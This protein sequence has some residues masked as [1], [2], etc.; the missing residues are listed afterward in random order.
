LCL[1]E[2]SSRDI[3]AYLSAYVDNLKYV[4]ESD[5]VEHY[6]Q[7]ELGSCLSINFM[8]PVNWYLDCRYKWDNINRDNLCQF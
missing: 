1:L 3:H 2:L 7:Q 4:L 6:L 8:G 5:E